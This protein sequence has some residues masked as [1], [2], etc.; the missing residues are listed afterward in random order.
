VL[1][2]TRLAQKKPLLH[3]PIS[4]RRRR[5]PPASMGKKSKKSAGR[6]GAGP[7]T[8]AG[9]SAAASAV[10]TPPAAA[11]SSTGTSGA[12]FESSPNGGG[13]AI[14]TVAGGG[15]SS[16][17][18]PKCVRCFS[19]L[20]DL[21]KA[22][23]CPGCSRLF[24]WR[25]ERKMFLLCPNGK[26]C[27]DPRGR[28]RE[29]TGGKAM[30]EFIDGFFN[31]KDT[32]SKAMAKLAD[33]LSTNDESMMKDLEASIEECR[34]D[35]Q[36][37][38]AFQ[39]CSFSV[40]GHCSWK[41]PVYDG[42]GNLVD[43]GCPF[44]C[45]ACAFDTE[46]SRPSHFRTCNNCRLHLCTAC[47]DDAKERIVAGG[48]TDNA[49]LPEELR[50]KFSR[51]ICRCKEC[52]RDI[53]VD[54]CLKNT[55]GDGEF[56]IRPDGL[57]ALCPSC[58]EEKY[59][60]TKPCTNPSCQNEVGVPTKR[61][62][63]CHLD[64]YCSVECQAAAYPAHAARCQKIQAKRAAAGKNADYYVDAIGGAY[65]EEKAEASQMPWY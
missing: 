6:A 14:V 3:A 17:K 1:V 39:P 56:D 8:P 13:G 25:C 58:S 51:T 16:G 38:E 20:K 30:N 33:A 27:A 5:V 2:L 64:R 29:C 11:S 7:G 49:I 10:V 47:N 31:C 19:T 63:G 22:H 65:G 52:M 54:C 48:S 28:C 62:G 32:R 44:E 9:A 18:K 37:T 50:T 41:G 21:A 12:G 24:C 35:G 34:K 60:S 4:Y 45:S 15:G 57:W 26:N 61:C 42:K 59:W 43:W 46:T 23:G 55:M 53:C 36:A 40:E